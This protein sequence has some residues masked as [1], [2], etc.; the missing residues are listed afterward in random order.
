MVDDNVDRDITMTE[1]VAPTPEEPLPAKALEEPLP[2]KAVEAPAPTP[3]AIVAVAVVA[4]STLVSKRKPDD[5]RLD[6]NSIPSERI[7]RGKR[8]SVAGLE[9]LLFYGMQYSWA[10]PMYTDVSMVPIGD[11]DILRNAVVTARMRIHDQPQKFEVAFQRN[12]HVYAFQC[13]EFG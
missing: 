9:S 3:T 5:M 2:A 7:A 11:D 13:M 12:F 10:T 8:H 1:A 6:P 4:P